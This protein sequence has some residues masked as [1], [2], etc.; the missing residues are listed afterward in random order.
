MKILKLLLITSALAAALP[1]GAAPYNGTRFG[2][3]DWE[4]ACDNTRRCEAA[5]FQSEDGETESAPAALWLGRD[6]GAAAAA[7]EA[8]LMVVTPDDKD[9]GPLTITAGQLALAGLKAVLLKMDDLQGRV[10]T[11]TAPVKPG[12]RPAGAVL[13][14][15]AMPPAQKGD[16]KLL[17]AIVKTKRADDCSE[18]VKD[19]NR[20][21][22]IHRPPRGVP[23]GVPLRDWV[24][25][26]VK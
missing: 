16:D 22:D 2:A 10:G 5:G 3:M 19:T 12:T 17:A 6:A 18:D 14:P 26:E 23:G 8:R 1:A 20:Y 4:V 21:Q 25:Q 11:V 15:L 9:A 24:A 7:L 13:P